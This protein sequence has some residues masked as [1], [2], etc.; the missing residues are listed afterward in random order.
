MSSSLYR[1]SAEARA[2]KNNSSSRSDDA[3]NWAV[4]NKT[5]FARARDRDVVYIQDRRKLFI[6]E[7][8]NELSAT[9]YV[10]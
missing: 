2:L 7:R 6:L 5:V 1:A 10:G 8:A 9:H 4:L 3:F